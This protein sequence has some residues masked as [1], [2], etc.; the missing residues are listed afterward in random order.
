MFN[1][2]HLL[3]NGVLKTICKQIGKIY[4]YAIKHGWLG[5]LLDDVPFGR[6]RFDGLQ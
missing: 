6:G 1:S 4:T 5:K 3:Y 2:A